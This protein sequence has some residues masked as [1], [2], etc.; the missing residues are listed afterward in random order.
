MRR[1]AALAALSALFASSFAVV[2][3]PSD[4]GPLSPEQNP[5]TSLSESIRRMKLSLDRE[6]V[7]LAHMED[8]SESTDTAGLVARQQSDDHHGFRTTVNDGKSLFRPIL[9]GTEVPSA[10]MSVDEPMETPMETDEDMFPPGITAPPAVMPPGITAP[11]AFMPPGITAP[12]AFMPPGITAPPAFM[13]PGITAPPAFMPPGITATPAVM[14]PGVTEM[15]VPVDPTA[16]V[17]PFPPTAM[18]T[19]TPTT[20][21][22]EAPIESLPPIDPTI[23]E[24]PRELPPFTTPLP[25]AVTTISPVESVLPL[26][27]PSPVDGTDTLPGIIGEGLDSTDAASPSPDDDD[28]AVCFPADATVQLEDGSAKKM[29]DV[30]LGDRVMVD[31]GIFSPVFMFT[32]KLST[33][34]YGFVNIQTSSGN[35]LSLTPGHYLYVNGHLSAAS[36]VKNGDTLML[37]DSSLTDVTQVST[38]T[39]TG[40]F[41]PQTLHGDIVVNGLKASTYT[42]AVE[43]GLAHAL[44]SP[45][46]AAYSRLGFSLRAFEA[47]ADRI[48]SYMPSGALV[49]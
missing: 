6:L 9:P 7:Y 37:A 5:S 18:P 39:S 35:T 40:L 49:N 26:P 44:L 29:G 31:H 24:P 32:H 14:P 23:T 42:T 46:R 4:V 3:Q 15:P 47:G 16:P 13:P 48:A 21:D 11:P 2:V 38:V 22:P 30:Q 41:N 36:T 45:L 17:D 34:R 8:I 10:R 28:D 12:P 19:D 1:S 20:T 27:S 25:S 33:V 43:P